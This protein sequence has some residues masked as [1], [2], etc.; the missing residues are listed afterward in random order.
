M[1]PRAAFRAANTGMPRPARN[2]TRAYADILFSSSIPVFR[3]VAKT[4]YEGRALALVIHGKFAGA[5]L[6]EC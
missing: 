5:V 3:F 2:I 6:V 1:A 4:C